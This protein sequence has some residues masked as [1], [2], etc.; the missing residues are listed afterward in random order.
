MGD[1]VRRGGKKNR[2]HGRNKRKPGSARQAARTYANK[3]KR[4]EWE[5]KKAGR[6]VSGKPLL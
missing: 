1:A 2:K 5:C 6:L 4:W 3:L